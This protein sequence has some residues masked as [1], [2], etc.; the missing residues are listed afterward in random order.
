[1]KKSS[2]LIVL[3]F[4]ASLLVTN[5]VNAQTT[6]PNPWRLGIGVEAG[7]PVGTVP[8]NS[9]FELGGTLRLQYDVTNNF[10]LTLTTGYYNLFA[11][12]DK[13]L[14]NP[15]GGRTYLT[16]FGIVPLKAGIKAFFAKDVYFGAEAGVGF[17]TK[18]GGTTQ[19]LLSPALGN[20]NKT[21]DASLRYEN[22][23][24]QG[25]GFGLFGL[26]VAYAFKL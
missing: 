19:L 11:A 16:S 8:N 3:I 22:F 24:A 26:R 4:A 21:W 9:G 20:A 7:V 5:D 13:V 14:F 10:A 25:Y 15:G 18:S 1:M 23:S 12:G 6:N 2:V 17:E